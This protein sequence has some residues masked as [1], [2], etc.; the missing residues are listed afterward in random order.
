MKAV[1]LWGLWLS[2]LI[3]LLFFLWWVDRVIRGIGA[4]CLLTRSAGGAQLLNLVY[5][6]YVPFVLFFARTLEYG[7]DFFAL[8]NGLEPIG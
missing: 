6:V 5:L 8:R 7:F 3:S 2:L 1:H 4:V